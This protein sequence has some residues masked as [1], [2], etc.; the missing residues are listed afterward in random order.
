VP[1]TPAADRPYFAAFLDLR[2]Q[3]GIVVGGGA[4]AAGKVETLLRSGVRV[5]VI[6]PDLCVRLAELATLGAIRHEPRRFQ[7]GDL[8]GAEIAIAATDDAA[9]NEAVANSARA[10]R[11]PVNVADD[12]SRSTFIMPA[13][14]DR[15]P[16]QI[17]I[18]TAGASP[19]LARKLRG[20]IEQAVPFAYGRLAALA[21]RFREMTKAKIPERGA[22]HRFWESVID[23]PIAEEVLSGDEDK[24][25][26]M[27]GRALDAG[28]PPAKGIVYLVGA[29]A[30]SPES[31]TMRALRVLQMADLVLYDHRTPGA[32]LDLARR[33]AERVDPAY[34]A[35]LE[36]ALRQSRTGKRVVWLREGDPLQALAMRGATLEV[37]PGVAPQ[38]RIGS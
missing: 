10:L 5:T 4:V 35:A 26:Q 1:T 17:A 8:L 30:A 27:L 29:G 14:V 34:D 11:I 32:I 21:A 13:L 36:L 38:A 23:G 28:P 15:A 31:L 12:A 24:A 25:A 16:V 3:P 6:A 19:L 22:R 37:V 7:P 18:S 20:I 33:E 9:A 2:D